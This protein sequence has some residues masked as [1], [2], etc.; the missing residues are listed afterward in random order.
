VTSCITARG[1][2]AHR[3][4]SPRGWARCLPATVRSS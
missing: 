1:R 3:T 2:A 4:G